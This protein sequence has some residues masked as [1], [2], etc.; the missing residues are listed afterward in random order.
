MKIVLPP[1][2]D[3]P[4]SGLEAQLAPEP[5]EVLESRARRVPAGA[6]IHQLDRALD[7]FGIGL[8]EPGLHV[9]EERRVHLVL[10]IEDRDDVPAA[11]GQGDVECLRLALR[12]AA[13]DQESH[14]IRERLAR[15][16][17]DALRPV[18]VVADDHQDLDVRMVEGKQLREGVS[19]NWLLVP[20]RHDDGEAKLRIPD[21]PQA[22]TLV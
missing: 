7:D 16:P 15:L 1:K 12:P 21:R 11:L 4:P 19:E 6:V 18:V 8:A 5:E 2:R 20:G 3:E 10:G 14:A 17:N 9:P 13:V 22:G